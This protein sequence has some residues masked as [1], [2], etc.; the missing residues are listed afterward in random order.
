MI[1]ALALLLAFQLGGEVLAPLL[2]LPVPGPAIGLLLL[3][4]ALVL[5]GGVPAD[6][7]DVARGLLAY[8]ALLFVPA[9][10]GIISHLDRVAAEW[11]PLALTL[12][13]STALT[14]VVTGW[15]LYALMHRQ[16]R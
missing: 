16:E 14:M 10:V 9:G 5:R 4:M 12:I 6:L 11:L 15:T 8:L 13:A 2:G 1:G 7:G 3:F